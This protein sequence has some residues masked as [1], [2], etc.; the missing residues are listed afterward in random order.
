MDRL[1]F[2][3][4]CP[5]EDQVADMAT[6]TLGR[7]LFEKFQYLLGFS[8]YGPRIPSKIHVEKI[9]HSRSL[10]LQP[11]GELPAFAESAGI[12]SPTVGTCKE[13]EEAVD[14]NQRCGIV[15]CSSLRWLVSHP[16]MISIEICCKESRLT[17]TVA[18]MFRDCLCIQ[19]PIGTPIQRFGQN[20][21][22][23]SRKQKQAK[24]LLTSQLQAQVV[25]HCYH[26]Q[27]MRSTLGRS[28]LMSF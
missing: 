2:L 16:K 23:F 12:L 24:V 8:H 15:L 22:R 1:L 21:L 11:A 19:V 20:I 28:I 17:A 10:T 25:H 14:V 4:W 7:K 3:L 26:L 6:K 18:Q 13:I 27:M 9:K 5:G